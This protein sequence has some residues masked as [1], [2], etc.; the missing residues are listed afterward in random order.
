MF[1]FVFG[2]RPRT[3]PVE[4]PRRQI[5]WCP[6]CGTDRHFVEARRVNTLELFFIPL[7]PLGKPRAVIACTECGF[8]SGPVLDE[9]TR[10]SSPT[11]E[12]ESP[13]TPRGSG[14]SHSREAAPK[15]APVQIH[16]VFCGE[17][18]SAPATTGPRRIACP[19]CHRDFVVDF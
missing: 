3:R 17:S 11:W 6:I 5:G 9:S 1:F 4:S 18:I 2:I 10:P 8:D 15:A 13:S 7:L 14:R 12:S 16:C 19:A